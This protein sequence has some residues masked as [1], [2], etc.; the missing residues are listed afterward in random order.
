MNSVTQ[1]FVFGS[2]RGLGLTWLFWADWLI[3]LSGSSG[4]RGGEYEGGGIGIRAQVWEGLGTRKGTGRHR[5]GPFK[6]SRVT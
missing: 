5:G 1:L 4:G 2:W 6:A 3:E